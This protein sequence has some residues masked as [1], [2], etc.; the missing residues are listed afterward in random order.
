LGD[1][2][3]WKSRI[4]RSLDTT[5][6]FGVNGGR[7]VHK[8]F[9][10][11]IS[12]WT[13]RCLMEARTKGRDR[14]EIHKEFIRRFKYTIPHYTGVCDEK[15]PCQ[16]ARDFDMDEAFCESIGPYFETLPVELVSQICIEGTAET[17]A[18][19]RL[20]SKFF[21]C[22][23]EDKAIRDLERSKRKL[24]IQQTDPILPKLK[25]FLQNVQT[26]S[27]DYCH[28][29]FTCWIEALWALRTSYCD[30]RYIESAFGV[31]EPK[32]CFT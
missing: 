3:H 11:R 27:I 6:Y 32:L 20:V 10:Q 29:Y 18:T 21:Q 12:T 14:K 22:I 8:G 28:S 2:G 13:L 30:K 16:T 9:S 23:A 26:E 4:Y 24:L 31:L 17:R 19:L 25:L 7:T 5:T 1:P 15:C